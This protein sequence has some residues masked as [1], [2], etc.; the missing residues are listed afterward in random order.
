MRVLQQ[1]I[2]LALVA[3]R[4]AGVEQAGDLEVPRSSPSEETAVIVSPSPAPSRFAMVSPMTTLLPPARK[5]GEAAL[6]EVLD[7][8]RDPGSRSGSMPMTAAPTSR[9]E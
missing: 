2:G 3:C 8:R 6:D 1:H 5:G 4:R 9:P 7:D